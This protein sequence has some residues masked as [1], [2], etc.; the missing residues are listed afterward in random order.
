LSKIAPGDFV[1]T[2]GRPVRQRGFR[3]S[4]IFNGLQPSK[5]AVALYRTQLVK[6]H[7]FSTSCQA[8]CFSIS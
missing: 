7:H 5:M 3:K 8:V 6:K 2:F 4:S 1:A